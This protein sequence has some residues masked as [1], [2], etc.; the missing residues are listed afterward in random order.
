MEKIGLYHRIIILGSG[1]M[2]GHM[3]SNE[4]SKYDFKIF[5]VTRSLKQSSDIIL[6]VSRFSELEELIGKI[7]PT[8]VINCVGVLIHDSDKHPKR[9]KEINTRLPLFL[10]SISDKYS[11]ILIHASTD[12]VFSGSAGP[13]SEYSIKDSKD[14][15]GVSKSMGEVFSERCLTIRTSIIGPDL[16]PLGQGLFN[17]FLQQ[18]G[19]SV[20]GYTNV[21]WGGV[22][23]L[24]F[25]RFIIRIINNPISGVIHLTNGLPISKFD[26]L[27][28]IKEYWNKN[29]EIIPDA[30]VISDR[31]LVSVR[32]KDFLQVPDYRIMIRDL[33]D[34]YEETK[35]LYDHYST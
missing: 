27:S 26:L 19:E 31:S 3:I 7:K 23:T 25:A 30:T 15:Y 33:H 28:L 4:L 35:Y 29:I 24:E 14:N 13:Y 20:K 11:F 10:E 5:R 21:I 17:W 18:K 1:G 8:H 34:S 9:A 6:D 16:N 22:T 2:L 32:S 12:C